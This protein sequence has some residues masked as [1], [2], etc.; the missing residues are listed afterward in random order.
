V[1]WLMTALLLALLFHQG[2]PRIPGL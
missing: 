2:A 1:F